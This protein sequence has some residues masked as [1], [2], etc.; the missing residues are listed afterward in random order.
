MKVAFRHA[1]NKDLPEISKLIFCI[2][3]EYGL[4]SAPDSTDIDLLNIE[5][6]YFSNGGLFD[7]LTNESGNIIATVGLFNMRNGICE[8]RKMYLLQYERGK[9]FGKIILEHAIQKAK[10]LGYKKIILETASVLKEAIGLYE[11]YGFIRYSPEHLSG[12]CDK[13]YYLELSNTKG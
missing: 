5:E 1:T 13:A 3:E 8:L 7:V 9:G 12:R 6:N 4:K 2:L 10:E 11:R